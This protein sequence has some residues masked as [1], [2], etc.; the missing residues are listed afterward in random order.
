MTK[1]LKNSI[2]FV[3]L[4]DS[5]GKSLSQRFAEALSMH[6]VDTKELIEYDLFNSEAVLKNCGE[7][8]YLMRERRVV[9]MACS[10]ENTVIF[11][12]YD[13]FNHNQD[14]FQKSCTKVYLRLSKK[15]LSN[16]DKLSFLAFDS[17]DGELAKKCDVVVG[18]KSLNEKAA[19]KEIYNV[20]G[21]IK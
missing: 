3:C 18:L 1:E 5:F 6:F 16:L 17:R 11:A 4:N 12:S 9:K 20:L 15:N 10:Y 13:I 7:E 21:D 14:I 8:Y 19:L 2:L